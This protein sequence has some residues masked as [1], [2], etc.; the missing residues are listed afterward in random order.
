MKK[1]I[2]LLI[3]LAALIGTA[4]VYEK[5]Q[6]ENLNTANK[7]GLKVREFLLPD[8]NINDIQGLHLK[9]DKSAVTVSIAE[10]RL[11]ATVAERGGYPAS[12]DRISSVLRDLEAQKIANKQVVGKSAWPEIKVVAP[13]E[14]STGVGTL[15]ELKP[16]A[17]KQGR[18]FVLGEQLNIAGGRSSTQFS[19]GAQR[20]VRIPDDGETIWVIDNTFYDLDPKPETWLDKAFIDVQKLKEVTVTHPKAEDSWKVSR[21]DENEQS[22]ALADLKP[23]EGL[24]SSKLAISTLLSSPTFNDVHP[25]DKAGELLKDP[26]K[27]KLIT[28]DGFT[29]D[30]QVAKTAGEGGDKYYMTVAVSATIPQARTPEK[31]EKEEDK[32]KR[33]EEFAAR[34]KTLEEKLAK[35]QKFAGW[36]YEVSEYTVNNLLKARKD[37]IRKVSPPEPPPAPAPSPTPGAA[38]SPAPAPAA[39]PSVMTPPGAS[40]SINVTTPPIPLPS[41][42]KP[43]VKPANP[44]ASPVDAPATAAPAAPAPAPAATTPAT[45]GQ[46][47]PPP[48]AK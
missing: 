46:T 36:V 25:K 15:V 47:A 14:G 48:A 22:F 24:D 2:L 23:G 43:E 34:K 41:V 8:L 12:V 18:S 30:L 4:V 11:S 44:D 27:A 32:K 40:P 37:I 7:R 26:V 10:D 5:I 31:D 20:F 19:G 38:P 1:I 45:Q 16:V 39:P 35:E 17:G 6:N 29:Y 13:G 9:D 33:D 42:P 3:V 21:P 28:F